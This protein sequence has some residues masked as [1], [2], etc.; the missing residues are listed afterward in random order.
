MTFPAWRSIVAECTLPERKPVPLT[1]G[2]VAT[3]FGVRNFAMPGGVVFLPHQLGAFAGG[4]LG[5][6]V[7][8]Q[9]GSYQTVWLITV[10]LAA[11]AALLNLPVSEQAL[12]RTNGERA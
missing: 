2:A 6:Y 5:G 9:T 3:I 10:G 11:V 1:N 12:H 8:D 4:W 7:Y